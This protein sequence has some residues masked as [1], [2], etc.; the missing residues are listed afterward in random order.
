MKIF[1]AFGLL[2]LSLLST[3]PAFAKAGGRIEINQEVADVA[4]EKA[5]RVEP[6]NQQALEDQE[7]NEDSLIMPPLTKAQWNG[8]PYPLKLLH[9]QVTLEALEARGNY[10]LCLPDAYT[11]VDAIEQEHQRDPSNG[12]LMF[13]LVI[14][15]E[16]AC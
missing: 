5:E 16:T 14:A 9:A 6:T 3:N 7:E 4:G 2:L 15:L 10:G 13:S 11:F 8:L 12:A 1:G